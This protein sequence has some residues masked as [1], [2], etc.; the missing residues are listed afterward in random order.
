MPNSLLS[1]VE[2]QLSSVSS[3][4]AY[5]TFDV[6]A[7]FHLSSSFPLQAIGEACKLSL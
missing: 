1:L 2:L 7:V 5:R 6:L 3:S 4:K